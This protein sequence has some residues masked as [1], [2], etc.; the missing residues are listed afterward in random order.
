MKGPSNGILHFP[1]VYFLDFLDFLD[2]FSAAFN[3]SS[4]AFAT[5]PDSNCFKK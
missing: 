4:R 3:L 1:V 2:F 5:A